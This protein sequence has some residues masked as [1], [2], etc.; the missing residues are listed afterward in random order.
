[1]TDALTGWATLGVPEPP[2][3]FAEPEEVAA[4]AG[5]RIAAAREQAGMTGAEPGQVA[6]LSESQMSRIES[7]RRRADIAG[8]PL[9]AAALGVTVRELLGIPD[10]PLRAMAARPAASAPPPARSPARQGGQP[11][12]VPGGGSVQP[13]QGEVWVDQ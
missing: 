3:E 13:M 9:I 12:R 4:Q 7:G 1:M 10:S 6:G 8:L 5:A 2:R 11:F